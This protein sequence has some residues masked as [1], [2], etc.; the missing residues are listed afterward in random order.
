MK[1]IQDFYEGGSIKR[2]RANFQSHAY[3]SKNHTNLRAY[4]MVAS[5]MDRK[6]C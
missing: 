5:A 3:F 2:M 6:L 1:R 4:S